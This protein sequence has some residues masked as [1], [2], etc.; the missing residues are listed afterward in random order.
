MG[1]KHAHR[2]RIG[3]KIADLGT[4][5]IFPGLLFSSLLISDLHHNKAWRSVARTCIIM[6]VKIED[7]SSATPLLALVL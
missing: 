4:G 5:Q 7:L 6:K 3:P 1:T 2:T